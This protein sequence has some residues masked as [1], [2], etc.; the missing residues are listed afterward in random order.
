MNITFLPKLS[1]SSQVNVTFPKLA[2]NMCVVPDSIFLSALFENTNTKSWFKNNL[3]RLL[4]RELQM[5]IGSSTVYDN[6]LENL[7]MVY[8]DLW[9]PDERREDMSEYGIATENLRKLMS[10]DDSAS[11]SDKDDNAIFKARGKSVKIKL[12]KVFRDQ[13]LFAPAALNGGVEYIFKTPSASEI[14]VAQSGESVGDYALKLIYE[15]IESSDAYSQAA[16]EYSDTDFPFEDINY[17]RP[18]NWGKDQTAVVEAINIP[19]KSMRAIVILFKHVDTVDSE[20]YIFPNIK[21]VDVTIDGRPNAVYTNGIGI[22]DL[23]REARRIFHVK[24]TNMTE[25]KFYDNKFALV[26]DL[27]CVDDNDAM[28]AGYNV[29]DTKAGVQLIITKEATTKDVKGEIY[30]LSDAAISIVGGS[31][32]RLELTNK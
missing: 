32:S 31:F 1:S 28:G 10:G 18:T 27:R 14:M 3:G 9:L 23:Y 16:T 26:V 25:T 7:I 13:D 8:K 4:C 24:D 12:G 5:R 11:T 15:F 17:I 2:P 22:D 30:V 20:E 19:R 29:S 6:K 21:R